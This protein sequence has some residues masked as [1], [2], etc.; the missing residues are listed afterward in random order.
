MW[1][2]QTSTQ[3]SC[4]RVMMRKQIQKYLIP[5]GFAFRIHSSFKFCLSFLIQNCAHCAT[6]Q[7]T[8]KPDVLQPEGHAVTRGHERVDGHASNSSST[9]ST[10]RQ[11]TA[12]RCCWT[13]DAHGRC[14]C[15]CRQT[16]HRHVG[17]TVELAGSHA[18]VKLSRIRSN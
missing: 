3:P 5:S 18:R 7:P 4:V 9:S 8:E 11:R 12:A 15:V 10:G 14:V 13:P 17:F 6:L 2:N 1:P 16:E